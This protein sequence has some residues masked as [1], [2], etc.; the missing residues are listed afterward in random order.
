MCHL[1]S[2]EEGR[3]V[4]MTCRSGLVSEIGVLGEWAIVGGELAG[5]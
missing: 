5:A 3:P 4:C 2:P 1:G